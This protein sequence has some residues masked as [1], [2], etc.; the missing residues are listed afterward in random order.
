MLCALATRRTRV[1]WVS[2]GFGCVEGCLES[3]KERYP[4]TSQPRSLTFPTLPDNVSLNLPYPARPLTQLSVKRRYIIE[5][6]KETVFIPPCTRN[7]FLK[8]Y[9]KK[10][11]NV[12][13]WNNE[14]S[15]DYF[16]EIKRVLSD[17]TDT[18]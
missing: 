11:G 18:K 1:E 16:L 5:R 13:Y 8:A 7:V 2:G 15:N 6:D 3:R 14:D 12:M 10:L 17:G 4:A 9:S